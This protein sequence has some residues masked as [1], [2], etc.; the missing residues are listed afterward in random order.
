M[1]LGDH[2]DAPFSK[3]LDNT[4]KSLDSPTFLDIGLACDDDFQL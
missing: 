4:L 3:R 1:A 2:A